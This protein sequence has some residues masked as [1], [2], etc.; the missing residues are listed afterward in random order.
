MIT[1]AR[2]RSDASPDLFNSPAMDE[3]VRAPAA[4]PPL[5][6]LLP[7]D[8]EA[9]LQ[10]LSATEFE[11]LRL[12]VGESQSRRRREPVVCGSESPIRLQASPRGKPMR[13]VRH[14]RQ[15]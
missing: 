8:L 2:N 9:S 15:G 14:S 4:A 13:C 12:H 6:P 10:I 11:R 3:Y 5:R 1:R 7:S